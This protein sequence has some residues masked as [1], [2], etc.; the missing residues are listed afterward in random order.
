M[1]ELHPGP[2]GLISDAHGNP[3][4]LL[5]ACNLLRTRGAKTIFFLGDAVGYLPLE[6][7]VMALLRGVGAVCISGNHEAMLLERRPCRAEDIY[8]LA[9][10]RRRLP[11]ADLD[12]II[13]WPDHRV[14]ADIRAPDRSLL[15]AHGQPDDPLRTYVY[16]TSDLSFVDDLDA[17]AFACGHTHRAFFARRSGKLVVNCGSVGLPRDSGGMASCALLDLPTLHCEI[18]RTSFDVDRLLEECARVEPPHASVVTLLRL[19]VSA[20]AVGNNS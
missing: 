13:S 4:G 5:A 7:E 11:A 10:A 9:A 20:G 17:A 2:F 8:Q 15:L 19:P 14:V 6:R 3:R 16:P 18:L 12:E 1:T